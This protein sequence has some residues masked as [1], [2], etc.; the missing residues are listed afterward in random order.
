M[1]CIRKLFWHLNFNFCS[2]TTHKF[3]VTKISATKTFSKILKNRYYEELHETTKDICKVETA[4]VE[5]HF[6]QEAV[7]SQ[8]RKS[9]D[10][11]I[12]CPFAGRKEKSS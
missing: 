7:Y 3:F 1:K 2:A 6:V 9:A 11:S 5:S 8:F 10:Y 12:D 4:F